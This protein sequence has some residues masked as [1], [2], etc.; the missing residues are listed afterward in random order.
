MATVV[1][2]TLNTD[3]ELPVLNSPCLPADFP[4][5]SQEPNKNDTLF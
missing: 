2:V 4:V 5:V 1:L 3:W